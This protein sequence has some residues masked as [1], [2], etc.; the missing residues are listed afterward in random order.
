M[1][2]QEFIFILFAALTI[3]PA[4]LV[5]LARNTV[6]GAMCMILSFVGTAGL[7]IMLEAY[8][9]AI[10]E[11]LVYAGAVMVLF[12]FIIMLL[13]VERYSKLLP[14]KKALLT[15]SIVMVFLLIAST[16]LI[17]PSRDL[18][19]PALEVVEGTLDFGA[20]TLSYTT[21]AKS[22]GYVLF[23]KYMLPFEITGFLLLIAMVGI[24][25]LS[26]RYQ[27]QQPNHTQP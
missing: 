27:D 5:V 9:L 16:Y 12:L 7:F 3:V 14:S 19:S 2:I 18:P 10:L 24:I 6:T 1:E 26:K 25:I 8:L 23:S 20:T 11:V 17:A 21:S 13:N 22:F 4:F 15:S